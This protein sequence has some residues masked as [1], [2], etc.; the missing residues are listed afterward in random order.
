M[1][2]LYRNLLKVQRDDIE[3]IFRIFHELNPKP[4]T[5]LLYKNDF[6]LLVAVVLSAQSTDLS[7]NKA[8]KN[9]FE[10]YD[11]PKR[12]FLLGEEGL[13]QYI[14]TIGL[15]NSKAANIIKLSAILMEE[16]ESKVPD[17]I[18]D[19]VKLPGV[20]R[21]TANVVLGALFGKATMPV[22]THVAR[23]AG[24][25]KLSN[26]K[27]PD[28]IER[29]LMSVIPDKWLTYAHHWLVLHGR[30][31]CKARKP[32]CKTCPISSYCPY[33]VHS[34]KCDLLSK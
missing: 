22:D 12:M 3:N 7:V 16:Y 10:L 30:Y 21:K 28:K 11:T 26:G 18:E 25:L 23:V 17:N 19:L 14:K 2:S 32:L 31:I 4:K 15:Y 1:K 13:K 5:E 29:D 8:T 27:T 20:G 6:T 9:L 33:I 24:R 34:S